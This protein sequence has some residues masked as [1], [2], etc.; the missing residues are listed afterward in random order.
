[1]F[2]SF[3]NDSY[4]LQTQYDPI[5]LKRT[6]DYYTYQKRRGMLLRIH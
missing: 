5:T 6:E 1:M 3:K 4:R 2:L